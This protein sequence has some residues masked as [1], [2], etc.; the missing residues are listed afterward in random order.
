MSTL[1]TSELIMDFL[2]EVAY[3]PLVEPS[4]YDR[5]Q[6]S[7]IDAVAQALASIMFDGADT[8]DALGITRRSGRPRKRYQLRLVNKIHGWRTGASTDDGK[9]VPWS[10]IELMV[11]EWLGDI[12]SDDRPD[13]KAL[14]RLY[15]KSG[16]KGSSRSN[17]LFAFEGDW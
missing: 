10:A 15:T 4:T 7:A 3:D 8:D 2:N 5:A 12:G 11:G 9:P 1:V 16:L 17:V 14:M 6:D 13:E